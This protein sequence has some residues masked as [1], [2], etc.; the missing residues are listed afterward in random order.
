MLRPDRPFESKTAL[1]DNTFANQL[2]FGVNSNQRVSN[3]ILPKD[4]SKAKAKAMYVPTL[5]DAKA[6]VLYARALT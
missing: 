6:S 4:T 5:Y 1:P 2:L 3:E